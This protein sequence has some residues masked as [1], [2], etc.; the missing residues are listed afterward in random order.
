MAS[1]SI[2]RTTARRSQRGC[3]TTAMRPLPGRRRLAPTARRADGG[4]TRRV[5]GT[6]ASRLL[7]Q[8]EPQDA[9][10]WLEAHEHWALTARRSLDSTWTRLRRR[11]VRS[12][13]RCD[14]QISIR[15]LVHV[16][17]S[18]VE[19]GQQRFAPLRLQRLVERDA[20]KL[21]STQCPHEQVSLPCRDPI[22]G[23]KG[24]A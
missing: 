16:A 17:N 7:C 14:V 12:L 13:F 18:D 3:S 15:P 22:A 4:P 11:S 6:E 10:C 24:Q 9:A 23:V 8:F 1:R 20:L 5:R 21:L 19:L 2:S